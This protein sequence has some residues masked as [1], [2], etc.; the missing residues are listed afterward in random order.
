MIITVNGADHGIYSPLIDSM[1]RLR[2][3]VFADRLGWDVNV[4]NGLE[5][6]RFDACDPLYILSVDENKNLKGC[7]RLLPTTGPNMLRDVFSELVARGEEI[8]SPLIWESTRF[9]VSRS[10]LSERTAGRLNRTTGELLLGLFEVAQKAGLKYVVSVYDAH[11]RRI[12]GIAGCHAELIGEPK[13][14]GNVMTYAG[15]FEV[16][17][18]MIS[19]LRAASGIRDSV[20][21]PEDR[22]YVA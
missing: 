21:Y 4:S 16:G 11:M 13:C 1:H 12:L 14:I 20:F 18:T 8:E 17:D 9:C 10:A 22:R 15:L 3:E 7:L 5:I 19:R 6:D 2:A